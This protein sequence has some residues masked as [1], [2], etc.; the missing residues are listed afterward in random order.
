[1]SRVVVL[2]AGIIGLCC[3]RELAARGHCVTVVERLPED[4]DGCSFGNAGMI[5]P[6][7]FIPLAAPGMTALA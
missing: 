5:V 2:G 3:A 6:S 7:H 4:R 1:M